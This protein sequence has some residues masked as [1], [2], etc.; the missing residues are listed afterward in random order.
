MYLEAVTVCINYGDF[1]EEIVPFNQ[2]VFDKWVIVTTE[3]DRH[4][5]AICHR[6][7]IPYVMTDEWQRN[8]KFNKGRCV[9]RGLEMLDHH[10]W[11]IHLDADMVL[12][13]KTRTLLD[14]AHL[15]NNCLY[16][17]DRMLVRGWDKWQELKKNPR[18]QHT[19]QYMTNFAKDLPV[20]ARYVTH[21][22][23]YVPI[24][25]FQMWHSQDALRNG[26]QVKPM[27]YSQGQAAHYDIQ[28]ALQ[29][30]RR[31]RHVI[32]EII[33]LHLESDDN[34]HGKNWQ[35]R[36]TSKF[37]PPSNVVDEVYACY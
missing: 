29:W 34:S 35:G 12:P 30:D 25:A 8:G 7:S 14:S 21:R 19:W 24:G 20:G 27:P 16:G 15:E 5:K 1:L 33:A 17:I 28:F 36:Q 31:K 37:G 4:T 10:D 26:V 3:S 11:V 23:G 18:I 6:H 2:D 9:A 13:P 22:D 32:P